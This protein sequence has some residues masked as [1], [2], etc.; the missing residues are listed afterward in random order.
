MPSERRDDLEREA[1][2]VVAAVR[3]G[4]ASAGRNDR[5]PRRR[6]GDRGAFAS[7]LRVSS[8]EWKTALTIVRPPTP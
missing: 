7:A 5:C 1:A 2:P 3:G 8:E 4:A 6:D